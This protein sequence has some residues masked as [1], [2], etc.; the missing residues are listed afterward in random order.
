MINFIK[1]IFSVLL[2]PLILAAALSFQKHLSGYPMN[3]EDFFIWGVIGF[4]F[5]FLFVFQVW[6]VY[7]TGQRISESIFRFLSPIDRFAAYMFPVYLLI[8]FVLFYITVNFFNTNKLDHYFMFFIGFLFSMHTL[9]T[10]QDL[11][12]MEKT[13]IKPNYLFLMSLIFLANVSVV[14][15]LVDLVFHKY[16][17]PE[18]LKETLDMARNF[19]ELSFKKLMFFKR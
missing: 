8:T 11:Q 9:M 14:I 17:F 6:G 4:L 19:Y 2:A 1:F 7:E 15:L 16:T 18:Y 5:I 13:P 12:E 10:A 3:Y